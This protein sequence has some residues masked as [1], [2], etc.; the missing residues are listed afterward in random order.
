MS[1]SS[2]RFNLGVASA[3]LLGVLSL[4][5]LVGCPPPVTTGEVRGIIAVHGYEIDPFDIVIRARP[6]LGDNGPREK[7]DTRGRSLVASATRAPGG[8]PSRFEFRISGLATDVSYRIGVKVVNQEIYPRLAWSANHDAL[9]MAGDSSL[10]FDAY[11][12]HSEIE[13]MGS[14]EG[15]ERPA[16]VAADALEFT[17]PERASRTFRWRCMLPDVTGGQLQISVAP[18]PRIAQ[19]DYDPCANGEE[20]I[21]YTRDFEADGASG[22]WATLPPVDFHLLLLEGRGDPNGNG[23]LPLG[24]IGKARADAD[25]DTVVLPKL[26]AGHPLYARVIPKIGDV[27]VCDPNLAGV[28]PETHLARTSVFPA[29]EIK[30]APVSKVSI[31][32]VW[33]TKPA[34]GAR[35]YPGET[36]Y[37]IV[38]DHKVASPFFGSGGDMWDMLALHHMSGV[39]Y[40]STVKR[41]ASFCVPPDDD[42]EGFLEFFVDSWSAVL[43]GAIDLV[44]DAVNYAS[45]LWEEIQDTVVDV[46]ASAIDSAGIV[47]CG[48]GSV[49]RKGL[50]TGLEIGLASMGIPPSLPNFDQLVDQGLD[51]LAAQVASQTGIPEEMVDY[52]SQQ[53]K[54]FVTEAAKRMKSSYSVP[55]LPNWLVPDI[56]FEPAFLGIEL[57][58]PGKSSPF[59]YTPTLWRFNGTPGSLMADNIYRTEITE[60]PLALPRQGVEPPLDYQMVLQPDMKGLAPAPTVTIQTLGGTVTIYPT[61]YAK[62][63]WNKNQWIASRYGKPFSCFSWS[64]YAVSNH[65]DQGSLGNQGYYV[66]ESAFPPFDPTSPCL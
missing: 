26:E 51:Y 13:V 57:Y 41:N 55:G 65:P 21:I 17:D 34:Y 18:F 52:A 38:K 14:A 37:R 12:V 36:C 58:G 56:R 59:Y 42:D 54:K 49:C 32:N 30:P 8:D 46:A 5:T 43:T 1:R 4:T 16:W 53:A 66:F 10:Q 25:W 33:Y 24:H 3:V 6:L 15:R 27:L 63:V 47:D 2:V 22:E 28:L 31:G 9:T 40:G 20:G 45:K 64:L 61:Q 7:C 19:Q 23:I 48:K 44:A 50:E 35:P 29:F 39:S 11:A 62:A 60:L